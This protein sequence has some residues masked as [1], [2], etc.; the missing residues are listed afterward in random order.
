MM[1]AEVTRGRDTKK[2][3]R[4]DFFIYTLEYSKGYFFTLVEKVEN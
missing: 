3:A 2:S 1:R 4:R